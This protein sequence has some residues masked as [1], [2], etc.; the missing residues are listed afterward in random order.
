QVGLRLLGAAGVAHADAGAVVVDVVAHC[1]HPA[2]DEDAGAVVMHQV[3]AGR[4]AITGGVDVGNDGQA[5]AAAEDLVVGHQAAR[6][7]DGDGG[8]AVA[9]GVADQ[10]L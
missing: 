4:A 9:G 1:Q 3:T 2:R 5:G 8:G 7:V 6:A 10:V